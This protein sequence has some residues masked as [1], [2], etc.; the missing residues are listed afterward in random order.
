MAGCR[1][2]WAR[3]IYLGILRSSGGLPAACAT[4]LAVGRRRRLSRPARIMCAVLRRVRASLALRDVG[5][6]KRGGQVGGRLVAGA[7]LKVAGALHHAAQACGHTRLVGQGV[8]VC[9]ALVVGLLAREHV[10]QK[11]ADGVHVGALVGLREAV[12]LGGGEAVG[13]QRRGVARGVLAVHARDAQVDEMGAVGGDHDV[14]GGEVAMKDAVLVQGLHRL[15]NL[16]R[17]QH[18]LALAEAALARHAVLERLAGN[19]VVHHHEA[20]GQLVGGLDVGQAGTRAFGERRPHAAVRE[21]RGDLLAHE[22]AG[23]AHA[24]QLGDAARALGERAVDVVDVVDAHAVHD[25]PFVQK[26]PPAPRI[27]GKWYPRQGHR[28]S[29]VN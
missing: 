6:G 2:V 9:A 17:Q 27:V 8:V 22:G 11:T 25:L 13:A 18:G 10:A 3:A 5:P 14:G 24:H 4:R 29:A 16:A 19:V 21:L 7:R 20:V 28:S 12:L 1:A 15:A 23:G 26:M